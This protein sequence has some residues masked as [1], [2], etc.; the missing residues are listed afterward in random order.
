VPEPDGEPPKQYKVGEA[1]TFVLTKGGVITG[2]VTTPA[3]DPVVAIGVRARMIRDAKGQRVP[4]IR[5]YDNTTD[6]RGI[7]RLYGLRAGTYIVVAGARPQYGNAGGDAFDTYLPTYAP[8]SAR[9]TAAEISVRNG[10]ETANIDIRYRGELGRTISGTTRGSVA[11]E[12][13]AAEIILTSIEPDG[14]QSN[15]SYSQRSDSAGFVFLGIADGDYYLTAQTYGPGERE[16]SEPRLIK[17]RGVDIEGIE[18]TSRPMASIT[19]RVVL[20]HSK[21]TECTGK[22]RPLFNETFI[23]AWHKQ[24]EAAKNQPQFIWNAGPPVS[25]DAQGNF[26]M[27]GLAASQ[28]FFAARFPAK[29]W[30]LQSISFPAPAATGAKTGQTNKPIDATRVWTNVKAGERR[31]RFTV[32]IPQ[33]AGPLRGQNALREGETLPEKLFVYLVPVEKEKADDILRFYGAAVTP[34][35]KI[36]M[37]NVAPGSYRVLAQPAGDD[38]ESPVRKLRWPDETETRARLR[39]DA[40]AAKTEIELKPCQNMVNFQVPLKGN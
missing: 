24:T 28:Y 40:E 22:D 5:A 21:A 2:I 19:G 10:E 39:R 18:L 11:G 8:S 7:Y 20:E 16:L 37:N 17:V 34:D 14:G 38:V 15:T 36:L 29:S 12:S 13:V 23:S 25:A 27:R 6:D 31:S 33:G 30:Y 32:K 35:G 4:G 26:R 9:D 3:G 1:V